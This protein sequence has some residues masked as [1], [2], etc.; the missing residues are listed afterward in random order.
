MQALRSD[1]IIKPIKREKHD[2][3]LIIPERIVKETEGFTGEVIAI[4]P[5]HRLGCKIGDKIVYRPHEGKK[6]GEFLSLQER[7]ILAVIH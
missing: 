3:G 6:C 4:G 5:K 7:H 1:V 2:S